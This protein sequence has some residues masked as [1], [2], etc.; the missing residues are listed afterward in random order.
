MTHSAIE[1]ENIAKSYRI[2]LADKH[3]ATRRDAVRET[4]LLPFKYLRMRLRPPEEDEIVWALRGVSF[5]VQ[6]G[7]VVGLIG[8]N[9]AGK[10]T[11]LK[12]LSRITEPTLGRAVIR[13]RVGSM[14]EVGTGFHP[15]LTGRENIYLNGTFLGMHRHE[16]ERKFDE[17]VAF[18]G[19]EKFLDTPV[20]RYSSGMYVRLAF[21]VAAHLEPEILLVDE[22]LSVGDAEFQKKSLG[23]MSDVAKEGRTILFV[24]HNMAAV[25]GLCQR[26]V[27]L[28]DGQVEQDGPT[29]EVVSNYLKTSIFSNAER[30]WA[31]LD[32]APGSSKARLVAVR[33]LDAAGEASG[34]GRIEEPLAV[35]VEYAVLEPDTVLNISIS[36]Y[37]EKGIYVLASPSNTDETWFQRPHPVG[38]YRSRV[39]IPANTLNL[40]S[41]SVTALLVEEGRYI[42]AQEDGIVSVDMVELGTYRRGYFGYWG[43]I[44]RPL[45]DWHTERLDD[46]AIIKNPVQTAEAD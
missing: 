10:S 39:V 30:V 37:D 40:G 6:P 2:G 29:G 46:R 25:Q 14:L 1:I 26:T 38:R 27:W 43:G 24:S 16:I 41:Y 9:G 3:P 13:G 11:L 33:V 22:V 18:S 12:I 36:V 45:L 42:L 20:K 4:L 44:V 31:D 15:E 35:E 21:A 34:Q 19:V 28:R 5:T 7:E 32:S 17:I 23:K 8:K